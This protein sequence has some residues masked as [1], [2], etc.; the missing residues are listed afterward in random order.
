METGRPVWWGVHRWGVHGRGV[1]GRGVHGRGV[2]GEGD[3]GRGSGQS[4]VSPVW[5]E[6]NGPPAGLLRSKGA[7]APA[8][9]G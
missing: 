8:C 5:P 6:E 1:H 9:C 2:H 7:G 4:R 3:I